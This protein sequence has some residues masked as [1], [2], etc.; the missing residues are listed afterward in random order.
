MVS[1]INLKEKVICVVGLGYV[2]LPLAE[3]FS[4]HFKVIGFDIDEKKIEKFLNF[5]KKILA[6]VI[7][8]SIIVNVVKV[9][10]SSK[11]CFDF[12]EAA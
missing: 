8:W 11:Y 7:R 1:K 9:F 5:L 3:E 12:G 10:F 6:K 4:K 2:G